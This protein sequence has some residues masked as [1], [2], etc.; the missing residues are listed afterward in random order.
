MSILALD[1]GGSAVK[2][3]IWWQQEL[4]ET[5][6]FPT[7]LTRKQFYD[8]INQLVT[9]FDPKYHL[10]GIALSCPG[11]TDETTGMVNGFSYVPFLHLGEF[12]HEF[13]TAVGLPVAMLND[14]NSAAL[15]EMTSGIGV[16]HQEAVFLIIGSGIGLAVVKD[17]Q[18]IMDTA[19]QINHFDKLM[20]DGVKSFNNSKVSPVHIARRVSLKKLK[21]PS[22]IEGK[23]VFELAQ[24]GDGVA[25][26]EI[27]NMYQSLAEIVISLNAAFKPEFI[28]IGGGV[29]NNKELLPNLKR[30]VDDLL[31]EQSTLL[32]LFRTLF[33]SQDKLPKPELQLCR[34]KNDAN[35][36]GAI[37]HFERTR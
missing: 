8:R 26:K 22:S 24:A 30:A 17:G 7:P 2:Y 20:A 16:G 27:E 10:T 21:L 12:Q 37:I 23:D 18:V 6:S 15:A 14:A 28:G 5:D 19:S 11:D 33:N 35:L 9:T 13:S 31:E 1:I 25:Y 29:S 32:G 4:I 36:L 3:G 34:Y